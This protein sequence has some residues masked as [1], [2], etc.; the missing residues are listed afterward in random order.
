MEKTDALS[1]L[2]KDKVWNR[3]KKF[4]YF[5]VFLFIILFVMVFILIVIT[6]QLQA[7]LSI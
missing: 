4:I 5:I 2:N 6:L 3:I 1:I 7:K